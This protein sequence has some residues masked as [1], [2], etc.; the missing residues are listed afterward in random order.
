MTS[1]GKPYPFPFAQLRDMRPRLLVTGHPAVKRSANGFAS[2]A[3]TERDKEFKSARL[4]R[5]SQRQKI[6]FLEVYKS[7]QQPE[8]THPRM[9]FQIMLW[10]VN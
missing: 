10:Q 7:G 4:C 9:P 6:Q 3:M 2:S 8:S 1:R 5:A